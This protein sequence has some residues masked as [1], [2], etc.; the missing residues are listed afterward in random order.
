MDGE[1]R[2]AR[3]QVENLCHRLP[4]VVAD[5]GDA[6]VEAVCFELVPLVEGLAGFIEALVAGGFAF[7]E[8]VEGGLDVLVASVDS[9]GGIGIVA[10]GE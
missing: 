6:F 2:V 5:G 7:G 3:T 8:V 1:L 10:G 9:P 4:E